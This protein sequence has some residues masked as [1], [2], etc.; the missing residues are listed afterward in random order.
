VSPA[1]VPGGGAGVERARGS[2]IAD[3]RDGIGYVWRD[4]PLRTTLIVVAVLN[5]GAL[6]AIQV[7]LPALAHERLAEGAAALGGAFAAWGIGSTI[8]SLVAGT[9]P[10]PVRFG[11]FMIVTVALL[12]VGIAAIGLAHSLPALILVMIA[13]G[14]VEG[15]ATTYLLSWMQGRTDASMQG[16]VMA[17]AM[18]ASVGLQPVALALAG[19]IAER[20]L[21]LLFWGSAAAILLTAIAASLSRSVR[22]M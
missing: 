2:A 12:G 15:I 19:A 8:G 14:V 5:L 20:D 3:V 10:V 17:L 21:G 6:G 16:R 1:I 4:I 11:R 18:L 22:R 13:L 7:G 9:R